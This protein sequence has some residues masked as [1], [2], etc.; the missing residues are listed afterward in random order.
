MFYPEVCY[1]II[2]NR[3]LIICLKHWLWPFIGISAHF[4]DITSNGEE[5]TSTQ[6]FGRIENIVQIHFTSFQ[7]TLLKG[8][9]FDSNSTRRASPNLV[10]DECGFLRVKTRTTLPSHLPT[11]EPFMYPEDCEQVFFYRR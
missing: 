5:G 9:W 11:H 8:K 4:H 10:Q 2:F 6:Y 3:D 1:L 7:V